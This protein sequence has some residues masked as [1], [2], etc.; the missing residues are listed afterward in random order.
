MFSSIV[1]ILF[2][3]SCEQCHSKGAYLCDSCL[4]KCEK[5][6]PYDQ[7]AQGQGSMSAWAASLFSYHDKTIKHAIWEIKYHGHFVVANAFGKRLAE[8]AMKLLQNTNGYNGGNKT[9]IEIIIVPIPPSAVGKKKRGY[10]QA[11]IIARALAD[12]FK[13][14]DR[15][16]APTKLMNNILEKIKA[17]QKQATLHDRNVRLKNMDGAFGTNEKH[18]DLVN[19]KTIILVDDVTTTGATLFDARRALY[20]AGAHE[21]VAVTIAH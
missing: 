5:A 17:T 14:P 4:G 10:N 6:K 16:A 3:V 1:N 18:K 15:A 7:F 19:G 13:L 9:Q 8:A 21:V 20:E 12:H 2:P 11:Y